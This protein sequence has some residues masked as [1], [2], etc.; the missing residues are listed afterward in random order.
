MS[1]HPTYDRV[2]WPIARF[3]GSHRRD[4]FLEEVRT[5]NKSEGLPTILAQ[6][7]A[8]GFRVRFWTQDSRQN[9]VR[10]LVEVHG[11]SVVSLPPAPRAV[12]A[13]VVCRSLSSPVPHSPHE[14]PIN[15]P[16]CS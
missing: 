15:S 11:G 10:R 14:N 7:L 13:S 3:P 2:D 16:T 9:L 8:G 5:W 12:A 6:P 1:I 4:E